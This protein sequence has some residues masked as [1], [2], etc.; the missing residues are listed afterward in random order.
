M[1]KHLNKYKQTSTRHQKTIQN[2]LKQN[3]EVGLAHKIMDQARKTQKPA[4]TVNQSNSYTIPPE[5]FTL[6]L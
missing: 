3:P 6:K 1:K 2:L 4:V 5:S